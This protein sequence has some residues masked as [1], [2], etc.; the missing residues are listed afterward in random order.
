ML[1]IAGP[2]GLYFEEIGPFSLLC[3]GPES[4]DKCWSGRHI[5]VCTYLS[6]LYY[7]AFSFQFIPLILKSK[8]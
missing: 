7:L 4:T 6:F 2:I 8:A 1:S 3:L 5:L